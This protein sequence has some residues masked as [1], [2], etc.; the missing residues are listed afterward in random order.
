MRLSGHDVSGL[1][2]VFGETVAAMR[3]DRQPRIIVVEC[4]R[5]SNH[6]NADD[7]RIYRDA[8]EIG[9]FALERDP[10]AACRRQLL[11]L[12]H[13]SGELDRIQTEVQDEV[14][15]AEEESSL[16]PEPT[17][18]MTCKRSLP[19]EL[20]HSEGER[21]GRGEPTATMRESLRAVLR[22]HLES[23]E[24]VT[25][26]G[27]DLE[28]PKGDV[29]GVTKGL[30]TAFPDRVINSPLTE[31]TILGVSIGRAIAGERPVAFLQFADFFPLAFNQIVSE[32]GS[33]HW[34]TDGRYE[35]PVIVMVAC[36]G[37]RP[38]LG[39]FHAQTFESV[40]A[41]TPGIDVVMPS[42]AGDAAGLLN[43]AFASGR[44]TI[45][46]YPKSLLNDTTR[47][48]SDDVVDQQVPLGVARR[49]RAG[50]DITLVGWGSTIV[51]LTQ[52][53][54]RNSNGW[55]SRRICSICA[56]FLPGT[57]PPSWPAAAARV[58]C[59]SSTKTTTPAALAE[60]FWRPWP[61]RRGGRCG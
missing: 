51:H 50:R 21:P 42:T 60:K 15:A 59:S 48:T 41:H 36:G 19:L 31:S 20:C 12:G 3:A 55:V 30:S 34:R 37:Y 32:L 6:T 49:L 27:Q 7:Q 57:R 4:E 40:A 14:A 2:R 52:A 24:R 53:V 43:T 1:D 5:L 61:N 25:L 9:R 56:R 17:A 22:H 39:P 13:T 33:M 23:D 29:F 26:Y 58:A 11:E 47:R 28:D 35:A 54:P 44:P 10:I 46:F 16:G 45:F 8:N 38:G 18:T